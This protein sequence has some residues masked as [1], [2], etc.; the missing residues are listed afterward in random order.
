MSN[1]IEEIIAVDFDG[2]IVHS[3]YP[4]IKG[5][6]PNALEVLRELSETYTIVIW[7]CRENAALADAVKFL[8]DNKV[9][10]HFINRNTPVA[11][12]MWGT[13][14][15]KIGAHYFIDDRA[16]GVPKKRGVVDWLEIRRIFFG[17]NE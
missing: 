7:T 11:C 1:K 2:T 16:V 13:D 14:P 5:L 9:P 6:I 12:S 8:D 15:R 17:G 4:K 3:E 10:Y